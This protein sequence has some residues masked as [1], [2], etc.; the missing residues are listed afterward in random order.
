MEMFNGRPGD[1]RNFVH[2]RIFGAIGGAVGGLLGG[3]PLGAIGGAISG[4]TKRAAPV[5]TQPFP[6]TTVFPGSGRGFSPFGAQCATGFTR[7][8]SGN[9]VPL[10]GAPVPGV[11][12]EI[13]RFLPFGQ[14]G[15]TEFGAAVMGQ[16][17]AALEPGFRDTS[18]A[19]CPPGTVLGMDRLC[20]NKGDIKNKERAWPRGRKPLLTGG[21][22]RCISIAAGAAKRL[23]R[24]TKQLQ[25]LGML[26][27]PSTSRRRALPSGHHAHVAH[28]GSQH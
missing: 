23:E 17:G 16:F 20:Y 2:K 12:G 26:K 14:T 10:R 8:S 7:D 1:R 13:Q 22:M 3:G 24:K 4:F 15:R 27:K 19:V 21:E 25:S 5:T 18:T 6:T 9:C 11:L 28:D